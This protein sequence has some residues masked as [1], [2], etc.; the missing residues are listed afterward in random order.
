MRAKANYPAGPITAFSGFEF[1]KYE[2]RD[3]PAGFENQ[4][5]QH[6][7]LIIEQEPEP[8]AMSEPVEPVKPKAAAKKAPR[9]RAPR[10]RTIKTPKGSG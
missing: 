8:V 6:P 5:E 10:K 4:A 1:V 7:Y 3:V 2:W 9:K